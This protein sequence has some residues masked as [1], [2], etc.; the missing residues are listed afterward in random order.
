MGMGLLIVLT[1]SL[2]GFT[3]WALTEAYLRRR[4]LERAGVNSDRQL[5][6]NWMVRHELFRFSKHTIIVVLVVL[7]ALDIPHL[8]EWRNAGIAAVGILLGVN[9]L[10]DLIDRRRRFS[11][12]MDKHT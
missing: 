5:Y 8:L 4:D 6:A 2:W 11:R 9:S 1:I 12:Y 3:A 10:W 7:T